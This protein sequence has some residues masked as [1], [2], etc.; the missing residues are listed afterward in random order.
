MSLFLSLSPQCDL[1]IIYVLIYVQRILGSPN[2]DKLPLVLRL[3][4]STPPEPPVTPP[5]PPLAPPYPPLTR[6]LPPPPTHPVLR[7]IFLE[8]QAAAQGGGA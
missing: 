7:L 4:L 1:R 8:E 5:W 3:I 6:P 2:L